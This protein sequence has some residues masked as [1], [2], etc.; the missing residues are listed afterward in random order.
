MRIR[1]A[2]LLVA[3]VMMMGST[4]TA[5]AGSGHHSEVMT[6]SCTGS[7]E[8]VNGI[9]LRLHLLAD[10]SARATLVSI[11]TGREASWFRVQNLLSPQAKDHASVLHFESQNYDRIQFKTPNAHVTLDRF[12]GAVMMTSEDRESIFFFD[13][14]PI[15]ALF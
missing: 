15:K 6:F 5:G 10:H 14:T 11:P 4:L 12:S 9:A 13:C 8:P 7:A 2:R 1:M 3:G